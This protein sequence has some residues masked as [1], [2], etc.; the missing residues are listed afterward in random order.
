[1]S[2]DSEKVILF[3]DE[4]VME[5]EPVMDV[6]EERHG[7]GVCK[8]MQSTIDALE[9]IKEYPSAISVVSLD[10]LMP[11]QLLRDPK[12]KRE[13]ALEGLAVLDYLVQNYPRIPVVCYS[14]VNEPEIIKEIIG[15]GGHYL[16]KPDKES[17]MNFINLLESFY[18][19]SVSQNSKRTD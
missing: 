13:F 6:M 2:D 15:K 5:V 7:K 8:H 16:Y 12:L 17:Y 19:K 3:I 4:H 18:S 1:M 9:Y 14:W 10:L 11:Y